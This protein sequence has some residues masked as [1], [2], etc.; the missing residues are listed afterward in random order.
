MVGSGGAMMGSGLAVVGS[1]GTLVGSA[2]AWLAVLG[3]WLAVLG[4]G[5]QWWGTWT[6]DVS[7]WRTRSADEMTNL[8]SSESM[9]EA[10][11]EY[12]KPL[13]SVAGGMR[14]PSLLTNDRARRRA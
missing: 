5:G 8:V 13:C 2:G 6:G 3:H 12:E 11:T 9:V 10:G 7:R 14:T 1:A 4:P